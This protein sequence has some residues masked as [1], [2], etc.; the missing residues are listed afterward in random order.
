MRDF[1][2]TK[3]LLSKF[4]YTDDC[5]GCHAAVFGYRRNHTSICRARLEEKMSKDPGLDSRLKSRD[6]RL[7]REVVDKSAVAPQE[8][9]AKKDIEEPVVLQEDGED[10][11]KDSDGEEEVGKQTDEANGDDA[12]RVR[13]REE[14]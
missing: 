8:S 6:I 2:I 3:E 5:P 10:D 13:E 14:I 4:G 11:D 9:E 12:A 1:K 7:G